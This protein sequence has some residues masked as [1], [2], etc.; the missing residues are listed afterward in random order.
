[1]GE[2]SFQFGGLFLAIAFLHASVFGIPLTFAGGWFRCVLFF[3]FSSDKGSLAIPF[4]M[5][6]IACLD[7]LLFCTE[8]RSIIFINFSPNAVYMYMLISEP[9]SYQQQF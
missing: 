9:R 4:L 1:M 5:V 6:G 2:I 8:R 3:L 7:F